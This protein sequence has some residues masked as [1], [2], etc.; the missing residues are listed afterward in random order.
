MP[1]K[2]KRSKPIEDVL[3]TVDTDKKHIYWVHL[4][5][6]GHGGYV[7]IPRFNGIDTEGI[8][9]IGQSKT[10]RTR[11][12]AFRKGIMD[13]KHHSEAMTFHYLLEKCPSLRR[14]LGRPDSIQ[15]RL[16]VRVK[17]V[18]DLDK[19][20]SEAIDKYIRRF[21]EPPPLNGVI[22]GKRDRKKNK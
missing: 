5:K 16:D 13:N 22:P 14:R 2:R 19:A 15:A 12:K 3:E 10:I 4:K 11:L 6:K 18:R 20:E 21:G 1:R 9:T 8:L 7:K 17:E